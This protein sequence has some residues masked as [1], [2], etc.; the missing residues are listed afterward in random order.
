MK[1]TN[2]IY[3]KHWDFGFFQPKGL[4]FLDS[5]EYNINPVY[6]DDG[7]LEMYLIS[8][9]FGHWYGPVHDNKYSLELTIAQYKKIKKKAHKYFVD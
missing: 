3:E 5:E 7:E 4:I 8:G 6:D 2:I 1:L 9:L